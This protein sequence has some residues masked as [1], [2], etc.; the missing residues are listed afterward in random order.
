MSVSPVTPAF[1]ENFSLMHRREPAG[2]EVFWHYCP[3]FEHIPLDSQCAEF[4][5]CDCYL[6]ADQA[7]QAKDI[8]ESLRT[9]RQAEPEYK[10]V[11]DGRP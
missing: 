9:R 5:H 1:L 11:W 3:R 10:E 7:A 8:Q 6:G 4:E 2:P